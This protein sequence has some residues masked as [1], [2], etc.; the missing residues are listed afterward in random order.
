MK[1]MKQFRMILLVMVFTGFSGLL[2]GCNAMPGGVRGDGNVLKETRKVSPFD[3]LDISGAFDIVL[4][5]GDTEEVVVE[6][7]ANLLPHIRTEVT[8][9]TLKIDTRRPIRNPEVL[10]VYVTFRDLKA[11]D[12]SGAVDL[13]SDGKLKLSN[14]SID[15]SGA[16]DS[17]LDLEINRLRLDCSGASKLRFSG[18]AGTIEMDLSGATDIFAY[19]L[20]AETCVIEISGAG[21]AQVHATK[22]IRADISG[23]GSIKYKGSP[24]DI[25]QQVSGAGSIRRAD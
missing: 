5:Q 3:A 2:S 20:I 21:N 12:A 10:R 22:K 19:D 8:G 25:D 18:T 9:S 14:L 11:I 6:A 15:A 23:A 24:S 7:D 1:T 17:K 16:S 13:H 4:R